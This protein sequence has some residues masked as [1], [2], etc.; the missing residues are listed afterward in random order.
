[1]EEDMARAAKRPARL[2]EPDTGIVLQPASVMQIRT[3]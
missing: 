2:G 1:L 3:H